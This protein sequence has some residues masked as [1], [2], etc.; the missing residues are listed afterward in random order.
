MHLILLLALHPS[1]ADTLNLQDFGK[2]LDYEAMRAQ[3]ASA[4]PRKTDS[5]DTVGWHQARE[6]FLK[7]LESGHEMLF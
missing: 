4:E 3:A 7:V 5:L 1:K 6:F 2:R